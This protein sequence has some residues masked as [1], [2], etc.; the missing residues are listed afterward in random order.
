MLHLL[1]FRVTPWRKGTMVLTGLKRF[2][3]QIMSS[4]YFKL[5]GRITFSVLQLNSNVMWNRYLATAGGVLFYPNLLSKNSPVLYYSVVTIHPIFMWNA[6]FIISVCSYNWWRCC[7]ITLNIFSWMDRFVMIP[8]CIL[9]FSTNKE[10][11][12]KNL[13]QQ[14]GWWCLM[15]FWAKVW[16][17]S[18]VNW[19]KCLILLQW[20]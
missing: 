17:A 7:S 9:N 8:S 19:Q 20:S 3:K 4:L 13:S 18:W 6:I 5:S 11:F 16:L 10:R 2:K 12:E 15:A 1:Y 14:F